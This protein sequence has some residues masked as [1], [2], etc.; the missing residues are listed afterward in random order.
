[1]RSVAITL[2]SWFTSS[3]KT[4]RSEEIQVDYLLLLPVV[5]LVIFGLIMVY[6]ASFIFAEE[7]TGNGFHFIQRQLIFAAIGFFALYLGWRVDHFF[8]KKNAYWV[9]IGTSALLFLVLVPGIGVDAGGAQRWL[10]LGWMQ[11]QPAEVAKLGVVVFVARQLSVKRERLHTFVGGVMSHLLFILPTLILLLLQPDFG[12]TAVIALIVLAMMFLAG[13]SGKFTGSAVVLGTSIVIALVFS[14]GY[15]M[16]RVAAFLDP[17]RDPAGKGFQILQSLVGFQ[18]GRVSGL[19][20]GN[21]KG[22]LFYLPEAHNDFIFAVIGEELGFIGI[23]GVVIVFCY[24][25]YRGTKIAWGAYSRRGDFFG[26][27]L[28]AGISLILGVQGFLNMAVAMGILPTK[29][30]ALPFVSYGGSALVLDLFAVGLLMS[31]YRS[32]YAKA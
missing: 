30:L 32:T 25:F 4:G 9:L 3:R 17:W 15:R 26:F 5:A 21:G 7:R 14:S 20:L 12:S 16:A 27:L 10:K 2:K 13:V 28:A 6:S 18:N 11:F 1:M 31:I 8:W 19:G 22:K 23:C 24:L 29:G